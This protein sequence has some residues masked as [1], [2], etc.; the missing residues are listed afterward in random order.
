MH[1]K[2]NASSI[3][4]CQQDAKD[5]EPQNAGP[6]SRLGAH[7]NWEEILALYSEG[8]LHHPERLPFK[9]KTLWQIAQIK[10]HQTGTSEKIVI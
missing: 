5:H 7:G 9:G 2:D 8:G 10:D 4:S 1:I 6:T 3:V